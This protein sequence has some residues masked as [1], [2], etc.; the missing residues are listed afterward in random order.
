MQGD[1]IYRHEDNDQERILHDT[2]VDQH[3]IDRNGNV[4]YDQLKQIA[5]TSKSL[6]QIHDRDVKIMINTIQWLGSHVGQSF[7]KKCGYRTPRP[8]I[9]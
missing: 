9:K 8:R 5:M 6:D 2:F 7:L 1:K 3:V 4:D